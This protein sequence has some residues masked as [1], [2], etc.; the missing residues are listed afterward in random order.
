MHLLGRET[1]DLFVVVLRRIIPV[2]TGRT[3]IAVATQDF[4]VVGE[5]SIEEDIKVMADPTINITT[6]DSEDR[7]GDSML[8]EGFRATSV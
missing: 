8:V 6:G 7:P 5:V 3:T 4:E 1:K 2:H